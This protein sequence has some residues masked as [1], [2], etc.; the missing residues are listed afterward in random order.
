[1]AMHTRAS[2]KMKQSVIKTN[3]G[4]KNKQPEPYQAKLI[5]DLVNMSW[6]RT[7]VSY[8]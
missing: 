1:M 6:E 5:Q 3:K 2:D 7:T 4:I 8:A